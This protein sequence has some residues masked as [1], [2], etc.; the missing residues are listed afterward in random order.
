MRS[1]KA[2]TRTLFEYW[3][4]LL[5]V[6]DVFINALLGGDRRET[7]SSRLGKGKLAGKPVHTALSYPVDLL[8]LIL[9][10]EKNHCEEN[11]MILDDFY[12]VSSTWERNKDIFLIK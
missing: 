9:A 1:I 12:A 6:L 5:Y 10:G 4:N 2:V 7:I 11:I 3:Y 8:F